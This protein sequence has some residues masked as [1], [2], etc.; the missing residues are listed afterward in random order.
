MVIV[1]KLVLVVMVKKLLNFAL[2]YLYLLVEYACLPCLF[3]FFF[4]AYCSSFLVFL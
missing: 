3:T 2:N 4:V 1:V